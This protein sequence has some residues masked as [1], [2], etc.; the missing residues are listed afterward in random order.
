MDNNY[1]K[2]NGE[3]LLV[4]EAL[5]PGLADGKTVGSLAIM[6]KDLKE[7]AKRSEGT[8]IAQLYE[9]I[10]NRMVRGWHCFQGLRRPLYNDGSRDGDGEKLIFT[11]RSAIDVVAVAGAS[12]GNPQIL[13]RKPPVGR[14]F[15]VVVSPNR[16]HRE[17][18][19]EIEGWIDHWDWVEEDPGF[20]GAPINWLDR[21]ERKLFDATD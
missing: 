11:R 8:R 9:L 2:C 7:R 16:N 13:K 15:M 3:L 14:T 21:F 5:L 18:Y 4:T 19:P 17:K 10:I 1:L 12:P 6:T 20:A